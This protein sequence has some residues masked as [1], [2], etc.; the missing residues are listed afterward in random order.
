MCRRRTARL[1]ALFIAVTN[2][3]SAGDPPHVTVTVDGSSTLGPVAKLMAAEVVQRIP[4]VHINVSESGSGNG[5]KGLIN[6][7]CDV[8]AMS[9]DLKSHEFAA[10]VRRGVHPV[11]HLVALDAIAIVVHPSNPVTRLTLQEVRAIYTGLI[12][13]WK[14]VGGP[15]RPIVQI[16]RAANSGTFDTFAELVLGDDHLVP[17]TEIVGSAG[18]MRQRVLTTPSAVGYVGLAFVDD[19][20]KALAIDDVTPTA[21][22]V[23]SGRYPLSR[24][25]FFVTNGYPPLGSPLHSLIMQPLSPRGQRVIESIGFVAVTQYAP[26]TDSNQ[27]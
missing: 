13:K 7:T 24:P 23:R 4:R 15:D 9:R 10:A 8:A 14:E 17:D 18:A 16:S 3:A 1:Y 27:P 2:A 12:T 26:T 6:G 22:T 5:V 25:L 20:V 21:E 11:P 19:T